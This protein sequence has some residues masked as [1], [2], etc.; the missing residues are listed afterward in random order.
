MA[1]FEWGSR[2]FIKLDQVALLIRI[3][4][5]NGVHGR[6]TAAAVVEGRKTRLG[7][8]GSPENPVGWSEKGDQLLGERRAPGMTFSEWFQRGVPGRAIDTRRF[9][10]NLAPVSSRKHFLTK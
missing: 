8:Q 2:K 10:L 1:A 6:R 4:K 3:Y 9:Q 7:L 5:F